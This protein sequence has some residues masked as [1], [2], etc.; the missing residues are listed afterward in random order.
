MCTIVFV[1]AGKNVYR[2]L[3]QHDTAVVSRGPF[4]PTVGGFLS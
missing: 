2:A 1:Q 4:L 3:Q